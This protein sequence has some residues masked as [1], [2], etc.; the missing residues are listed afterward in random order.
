ME[1]KVEIPDALAEKFGKTPEEAA[2]HLLE[3]AAVEGYRSQKLSRGQ[4]RRMLGLSWYGTEEFLAKHNCYL[5]YS[6]E[7]LEEDRKSLAKI[8][9][10]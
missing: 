1:V 7:D 9:G 10:E 4:V 6:V 3:S 8:L 5:H 2:R